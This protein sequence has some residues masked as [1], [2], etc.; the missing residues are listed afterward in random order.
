MT[1]VFPDDMHRAMIKGPT[2]GGH[3]EEGAGLYCFEQLA[4]PMISMDWRSTA[5]TSPQG[6]PQRPIRQASVAPQSPL[7]PLNDASNIYM[8]P[9]RDV[10]AL[11]IFATSPLPNM[12]TSNP[13]DEMML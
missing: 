11:K 2:E 9:L 1:P 8:S 10:A 4:S 7:N 5:F 12:R 13:A 3:K 6:S